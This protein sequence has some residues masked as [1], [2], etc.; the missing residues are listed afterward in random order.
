MGNMKAR[1]HN[2]ANSAGSSRA[3]LSL[4]ELLLVLALLVIIGALAAPAMGRFMK[5]QRLR[6]SADLI[7]SEWARARVQAMKRGRVHVFRYERDGSQY[8]VDYWMAEDD[9]LEASRQNPSAGD[10]SLAVGEDANFA[11]NAE[12]LPDGVRFF[13]G[14]TEANARGRRVEA[15]LE[16]APASA[17]GGG[18]SAPVL[19]YSDGTTS[20]AE[21]ILV[22]DSNDAIRVS[23]RGLTGVATV[24]DVLSLDASSGGAP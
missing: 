16:S 18:W 13:L 1:C 14:E 20:S 15:E 2:A 5:T 7:R 6:D 8:V 19:F 3:G 10:E 4:L 11:W 24:S 22:N 9:A 23:L 17:E 12:Q 21:V